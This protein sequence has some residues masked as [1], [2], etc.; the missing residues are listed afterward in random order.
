VVFG[1]AAICGALANEVAHYYHQGYFPS[2]VVTGGVLCDQSTPEEQEFL[3]EAESIERRLLARGVPQSC[4][5]KE[6]RSTN[7]QQNVLN[8]KA[9]FNETV[10]LKGAQSIISFGNIKA[11][12]RFLMTLKANWPEIFAMQVGVNA[13]NHPAPLWH[14]NEYFR[15]SVLG[16][17]E[18]LE[19]YIK[20]GWIKEVDIDEI[21][22]KAELLQQKF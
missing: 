10:S 2:I 15:A 7:S 16:Q 20:N 3:S 13:F 12:R 1:N 17:Y 14:E 9:L 18:R 11:S 21:N 4:I 22:K 6:Q 19:G 8:C 5:F